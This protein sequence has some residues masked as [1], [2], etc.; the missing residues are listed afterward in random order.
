MV[1]N[2]ESI[3]VRVPNPSLSNMFR[4]L[5]VSFYLGISRNTKNRSRGC[6]LLAQ[7]AWPELHRKVQIKFSNEF[8]LNWLAHSNI[9]GTN[10]ELRMI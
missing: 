9:R 6:A 7:F 5:D 10:N 1:R 3:P 8:P 4:R 2:E